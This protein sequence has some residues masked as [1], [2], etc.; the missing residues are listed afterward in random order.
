[1][2]MSAFAVIFTGLASTF[3]AVMVANRATLG[4]SECIRQ[5]NDGMRLLLEGDPA[6]P[7]DP[8]DGLLMAESA[9]ACPS[10]THPNPAY[11]TVDGALAYQVDNASYIVW[12]ADGELLRLRD[13]SPS[14]LPDPRVLM[15][16]GTAVIPR[17]RVM[18]TDTVTPIATFTFDWLAT[19][20]TTL[21]RL[22]INLH[23]DVDGDA[24]VSPAEATLRMQPTVYLRNAK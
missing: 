19:T 16:S 2:G 18:M 3:Q 4:L 12:I 22:T 11:G 6:N 13:I 8:H 7:S 15:G 1:M 17:S 10:F 21:V 14:P 23:G 24:L 9:Q 20:T 5:Y